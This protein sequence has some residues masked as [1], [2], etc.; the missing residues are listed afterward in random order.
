MQNNEIIKQLADLAQDIYVKGYACNIP[1]G[2]LERWFTAWAL[3][4]L[5][6]AAGEPNTE[7]LFY[8]TLDEVDTDRL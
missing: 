2:D 7:K 3:T 4:M 1:D 5:K 8:D 6:V